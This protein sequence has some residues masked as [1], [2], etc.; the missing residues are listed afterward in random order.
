[1]AAVLAAVV[2]LSAATR[3]CL[4]VFHCPQFEQ[5]PIHFCDSCPQLEHTYA[6]LSFAIFYILRSTKVIINFGT[7]KIIATFATANIA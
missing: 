1:M 2:P 6:I 4:N 5:R 7:Q 3:I